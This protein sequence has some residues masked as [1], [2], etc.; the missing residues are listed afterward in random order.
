MHG[1]RTIY[2]I[3]VASQEPYPWRKLTLPRNHQVPTDFRS[4]WDFWTFSYPCWDLVGLLLCAATAILNSCGTFLTTNTASLYMS[5]TSGSYS[6]SILPFHNYLSVL[7]EM[8]HDI[9][10]LFGSEQYAIPESV[11]QPVLSLCINCHAKRSFS[12]KSY[13]TY[14]IYGYKIK[15][16]GQFIIMLIYVWLIVLNCPLGLWPI[17]DFTS[18]QTVAGYSCNIHVHCTNGKILPGHY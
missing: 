7:Q 1:H 2:R 9:A 18:N 16:L 6:S 12:G 15:N 13:V 4:G 14:C 17:Q 3:L 5:T 11:C 10:I 8:E